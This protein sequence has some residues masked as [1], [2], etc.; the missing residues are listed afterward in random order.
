MCS[1]NCARLLATIVLCQML[2][3]CASIKLANET[4]P[5]KKYEVIHFIEDN[6]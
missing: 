2:H 1:G 3:L 5:G 4:N 6:I